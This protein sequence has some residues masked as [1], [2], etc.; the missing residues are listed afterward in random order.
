MSVLADAIREMVHAKRRHG[1]HPS[2]EF[3][4]CRVAEEAGELVQAATSVTR[5]RGEN[6]RERIRTEA[7]QTIAMVLRLLDEYPDGVIEPAR[8]PGKGES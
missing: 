2:A 4:A 3:A 6:R 8:A 1:P 7:V 5:G